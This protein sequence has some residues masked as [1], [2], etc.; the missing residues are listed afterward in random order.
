MDLRAGTVVQCKRAIR[1]SRFRSDARCSAMG[2]R[3]S[4]GVAMTGSKE[5]KAE[6]GTVTLRAGVA[7]M[8][9]AS[10]LLVHDAIA[11]RLLATPDAAH[12]PPALREGARIP[13]I[14]PRIR[15]TFWVRPGEIPSRQFAIM[16]E[17]RFSCVACGTSC[18]SLQLGPLLPADVDRLL[19]LDW[20]ERDP[21][22]Y[23]VDQSDEPLDAKPALAEGRDVFLRRSSA[24]CHFLR[25]DNLCDVH[26]RFGAD[27]KPLMC[28][29][30][31]YQYRAT[32]RGIAVA[33]RFGECMSAPAALGGAKVAEQ[34]ADLEKM[35]DQHGPM[36]LIPPQVWV[37]GET[38]LTFEEYEEL[39][40]KLLS[41]PTP[42]LEV[43]AA[44]FAAAVFRT[45]APRA[46]QASPGELEELSK[47]GALARRPENLLPVL[48]QAPEAEQRRPLDKGALSLEDRLC[49]QTLFNK[50]LFFHRDLQ[51]GAALLA[52]KSF[53]ARNDAAAGTAYALNAAWKTGAERQLREMLVGLDTLGLA[54]LVAFDPR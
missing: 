9:I 12:I 46:K 23:F 19:A 25:A 54:A 53:L 17:A 37:D 36:P 28:R 14:K 31:P 21:K 45:M 35:L 43:K 34:R 49:R 5:T 38:L 41:A 11:W 42:L 44:P 32:P 16:P 29:I 13:P 52:I 27:A 4:G 2:G 20:P 8:P 18:R 7:V 15:Q 26:A 50:D 47:R 10:G 6:T 51:H 30:F 39:E 24:G 33:M 3:D 1:S 40:R 22:Q 48:P